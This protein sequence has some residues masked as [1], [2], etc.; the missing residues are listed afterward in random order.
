MG[1][2]VG[3][4]PGGSIECMFDGLDE[5]DDAGLLA[6]MAESVRAARAAAARRMV[7]LGLLTQRRLVEADPDSQFQCID[8][9]EALAAEVGAELGITLSL[10]HI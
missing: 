6:T 5:L 9:W 7:A 2:D 8:D 4:V 3:S 1:C 10:I